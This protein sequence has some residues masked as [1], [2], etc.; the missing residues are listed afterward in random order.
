MLFKINPRHKLVFVC[1]LTQEAEFKNKSGYS[2]F[3]PTTKV[4]EK[5]RFWGS[6]PPG[7]LLTAARV[8]TAYCSGAL[9]SLFPGVPGVLCAV[10]PQPSGRGWPR[11]RPWER[12]GVPG[13]CCPLHPGHGGQTR[14]Q[15][16][17][18][19]M[20]SSSDQELPGGAPVLPAFTRVKILLQGLAR[21]VQTSQ[22]GPGTLGFV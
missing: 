19:G 15:S 18:W 3:S 16:T 20:G 21:S 11:W 4:L 17:P 13:A 10:T 14:P 12:A 6:S 5:A 7:L 9:N 22:R 1:L 2:G 8:F